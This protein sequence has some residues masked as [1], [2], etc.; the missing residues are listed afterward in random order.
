MTP[1]TAVMG[2]QSFLRPLWRAIG[3]VFGVSALLG[4]A[5]GIGWLHAWL[6]GLPQA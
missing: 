1:Q 3:G 4:L 6:T 5:Y 2:M